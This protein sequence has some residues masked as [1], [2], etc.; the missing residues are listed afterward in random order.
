MYTFH[1]FHLI[2]LFKKYNFL[3]ITISELYFYME[4]SQTFMVNVT[5]NKMELQ[6]LIETA[7]YSGASI[8]KRSVFPL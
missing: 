8:F 1:F 6:R 7:S 3:Y 5:E 4:Y 2:L